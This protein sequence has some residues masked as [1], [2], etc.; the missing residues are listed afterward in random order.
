VDLHL[1]FVYRLICVSSRRGVLINDSP[2][3]A[4]RLLGLYYKVEPSDAVSEK[5]TFVAVIRIVDPL[6]FSSECIVLPT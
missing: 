4:L 1:G 5:L 6:H 3:F 2:L